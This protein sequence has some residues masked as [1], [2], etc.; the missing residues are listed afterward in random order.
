MEYSKVG[1]GIPR[2][3]ARVFGIQASDIVFTS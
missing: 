1:M 2:L 3:H